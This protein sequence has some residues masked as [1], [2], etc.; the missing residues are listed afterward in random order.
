MKS[1][2][3]IVASLAKLFLADPFP[4]FRYFELCFINILFE[5]KYMIRKRLNN[6]HVTQNIKNFFK[7]FKNSS[8]IHPSFT[9]YVTNSLE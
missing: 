5:Q 4:L 8:Y 1:H 9:C 2:D 3:Q 6:C 7:G